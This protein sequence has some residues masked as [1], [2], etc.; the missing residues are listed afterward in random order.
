M[1]VP[2]T[3]RAALHVSVSQIR[4]FQICPRRYQFRYVLGATPEHVSSNLV[5]GSAVH[6]ALAGYYLALVNG[7]PIVGDELVQTF[8]D[9]WDGEVAT[10]P[11]LHLP[12]V[13][14]L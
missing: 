4:T 5:L 1:N 2:T 13:V 3:Q 7:D 14:A 9:E 6:S 8:V 12:D 11:N 10:L